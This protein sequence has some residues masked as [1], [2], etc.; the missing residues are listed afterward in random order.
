MQKKTNFANTK[1]HAIRVLLFGFLALASTPVD[2]QELQSLDCSLQSTLK[3]LNADVAT[4]VLF[5]NYTGAAVKVYWIDYSGN[6][7]HYQDLASGYQYVQPTYVT[8]PWVVTNG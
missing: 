1:A 5:V 7:V 3:S 6:L 8:H 4:S 2:A